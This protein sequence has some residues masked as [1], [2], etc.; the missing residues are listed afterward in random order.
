MAKS[1]SSAEKSEPTNSALALPSTYEAAQSELTTLVGRM[2]SGDM[3]LE[4]LLTSYQRGAEL[5]KF[6][7]ARLQAVEDQI[8]VLDANGL[9]PWTPRA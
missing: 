4:E 6:C 8:K 7:R 5:L 9:K 2:E 3:P 1:P